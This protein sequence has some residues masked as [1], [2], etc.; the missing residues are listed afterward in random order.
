MELARTVADAILAASADAIIATD[1]GG[2]IR[3][4]NSGAGSATAPRR[5]SADRS[6]SS[7]P[8]AFGP[9][10]ILGTGSGP[11]SAPDADERAPRQS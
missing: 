10:A 4:W 9:G 7:F 2:I 1:R 8:S 11:E 3:I 5:R 6:T